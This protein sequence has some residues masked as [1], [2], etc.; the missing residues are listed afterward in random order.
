MVLRRRGAQPDLRWPTPSSRDLQNFPAGVNL[1]A[2]AAVL[3]LGIPLAPLTLLA[4]PSATFL[5]VELLG[6]ALTASAWF[7]LFR[8]Y[9]A[10]HPLAAAIGAGFIGFAPGHGLARQRAPELRG[11]VPRAR[12]SSTACCAS[13]QGHRPVRDGVR[14]GPARRV[15]GPHRRGGAAADRGRP[16]RR[17]CRLPRAR[18][19]AAAA[20]AARPRC[21]RGGLPR[22]RRGA[23]V[24]AVR[25]PAELRRHLPP[26]GGQR[27]RPAV[28]ARH[29]QHRRRPVGLRRAVDEPHRGELVLRHPA[30]ARRR[31]RRRRAVAPRP[32]AGAR[33]G[34][35]GLVLALAR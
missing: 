27:P 3:G 29:P 33:R 4:G 35:R 15:A 26:P 2:N 19:A 1:M 9:L 18:A 13:P 24:V 7:W 17:R 20:D 32:R 6:L 28:G 25:R 5:V 22:D 30:A 16:G 21:G 31:G 8:R 11:A 34:R 14:A 10:V 23:A 12:S